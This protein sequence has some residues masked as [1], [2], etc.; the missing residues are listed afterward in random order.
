MEKEMNRL[1]RWSF[2]ILLV[3]AAAAIRCKKNPASEDKVSGDVSPG[4]TLFGNN[5]GRMTYLVDMDGKT[6]HSWTHTRSGGYAVYLLENS[7]ILRT[8]QASNSILSG[9]GSAGYVQEIDWNGNVVWEFLYSSSTALAHH[10]IEPMPNGHVLI[11]AWEVKSATVAKAAGRK[12]TAAMWPD[13]VI[14]VDKSTSQIVWQWH[15]WDHLIQ[16]YDQTKA[17]Y[18]VVNQHPELFDINLGSSGSSG[19]GGGGDWLHMN[20]ISYNA[21]LDQIVLTSHNMSELYVID[22]STTTQEAAGHTGGTYGKGGDILYRWGNPANYRATGTTYFSVVHCPYWIPSG[23][24]GAGNII[25]FNNGT[26]TRASSIIEITPPLQSDGLYTFTSGTAYGPATPAWT[27]SNGTSFYSSNQGCCQRLADGHTLITDPDSGY[28]FE[29][30]QN[31]KKAWEYKY[32]GQIARSQRYAAG[33]AG[34]SKL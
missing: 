10:D 24:P 33:Y 30:D 31:Q 22:H 14:E 32:A 21:A 5:D 13:H 16:D 8:A 3:F 1:T 34:L 15:A 28:I 25:A 9:G 4:Y 23:L 18:G 29:V 12:T 7:N 2:V 27:Y 17:N 26:N 19:P 6:V 11:I 20:G